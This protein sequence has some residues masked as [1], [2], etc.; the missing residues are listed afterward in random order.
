MSGNQESSA[1]LVYWGAGNTGFLWEAKIYAFIVFNE[2]GSGA[3][4]DTAIHDTRKDVIDC[5]IVYILSNYFDYC[6]SAIRY[7][8]QNWLNLSF[9]SISITLT[10]SFYYS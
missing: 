8:T 3:A 9:A 6:D 10:H 7:I 1:H 2:V 5:F 4:N